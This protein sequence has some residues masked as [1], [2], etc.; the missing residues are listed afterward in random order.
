MRIMF[1]IIVLLSIG[2]L[3]FNCFAEEDDDDDIQPVQNIQVPSQQTEKQGRISTKQL[4]KDSG[5]A[6]LGAVVNRIV[7]DIVNGSN[8][9][10][11]INDTLD[12]ADRQVQENNDEDDEPSRPDAS[13]P[14]PSPRKRLIDY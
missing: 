4:L 1:C 10:P 14:N 3:P 11:A 8:P 9:P 12:S 7:N 2:I 5:K 6:I 13:R